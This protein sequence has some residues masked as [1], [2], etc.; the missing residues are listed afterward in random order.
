MERQKITRS[1]VTLYAIFAAVL[2]IGSGAA[3]AAIATGGQEITEAIQSTQVDEDLQIV[4]EA[5]PATEDTTTEATEAPVDYDQPA[6]AEVSPKNSPRQSPAPTSSPAP[7]LERIPF[8]NKEVTPGDP[9]SYVDTYG[10]CPFYENAG[11]KGCYPPP[12]ITCNADW[13][14][15]TMSEATPTSTEEDH[16]DGE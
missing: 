8:T 1:L 12:G 13:S 10:Q 15:C 16:T 11:V 2:V 3:Y 5:S 9:S 4:P 14:H 6:S 7:Q